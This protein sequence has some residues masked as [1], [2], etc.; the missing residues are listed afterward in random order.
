ME[1][2]RSAYQSKEIGVTIFQ[3]GPVGLIDRVRHAGSIFPAITQTTWAANTFTIRIKWKFN[4]K[5]PPPRKNE[6]VSV[7]IPFSTG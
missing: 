1:R 7:E 4:A 3:T 5:T 2:E 6:L